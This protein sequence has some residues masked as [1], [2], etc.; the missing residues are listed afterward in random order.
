MSTTS[1][2]LSTGA[3]SP[4]AGY[5]KPGPIARTLVT[6]SLAACVAGAWA[7]SRQTAARGTSTAGDIGFRFTEI[8][9]A[10]GIDFQHTAPQ[11]D[12]RLNHIMA[13]V[14]SM[15]A[16]VSVVDFDSDGLDDLY[17]CNSG[18]ES[19]NCLYRN[20]G[21]GRFEDVA[22]QVG[23]A[24]LNS[25]ESGV[26]MGSVWADFDN[27]GDEDLFLYRWGAPELFRSEAG[28][29]FTPVGRQMGLPG[30]INANNAVWLDYDCD[31]YLDLFIGGYYDEKINL[32]NLK[33]TRMM[34]ESFEYARNGGRKYLLRSLKGRRFEDVT[35]Q[36]GLNS[37]RWA[38]AAAA[39]DLRGTG[40]PDLV[41][42]NDYGVSEYWANDHGRRFREIGRRTGIGER[43]KSGMNVAFGDIENGARPAIYIS[44]I[45]E[46]GVLIQGNNLWVPTGDRDGSDPLYT[47]AALNWNAERGGWSF[48]AQFGDLNNDGYLDLF[49]TNGYIS[50]ERGQDYW[51]DFSKIAGGNSE[52]IADAAHWPA[53]RGRSHSG[54]QQKR[55]WINQGGR[56]FVDVAQLV[57]VTETHDGR[58]LVLADLFNRGA[59]DAVVA[60]QRGPLLL[61]RNEPSGGNG[62]VQFRLAGTRANRSAVGAEVELHWSNSQ[63]PQRQVQFVTGG[64]GF[65]AQNMR[66]LHFGLGAGARIDRVIIRWPGG[67][68]QELG[69]LAINQLHAIAEPAEKAAS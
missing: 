43:P 68:K 58:S 33:T 27:D 19:K 23:L 15:G 2:P 6:L 20:L 30:W 69:S 13:E 59:L 47:N 64:S 17:V 41:V 42:A 9:A 57:G 38:L 22:D 67:R 62:W 51:Y 36:V 50:A 10:S 24:R 5:R 66:R 44:N 65:C 45:S 60:H 29:S 49:L 34:P 14:A 55:V 28:R 1:P 56:S 8:S 25:R 12:S 32:W 48:G 53:V 37:R 39:A 63:G 40:Y 31:G 3:P 16:A 61:Y 7:L 26:S 21:N 52:I 4:A 11:L 54:Y 18:E 46:E 35:A